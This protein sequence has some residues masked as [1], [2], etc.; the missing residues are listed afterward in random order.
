M[1]KISAFLIAAL[2]S[3][4]FATQ[5]ANAC[6]CGCGVFNV[7]TSALIPNCQ[8]GTAFLQYDYIDQ[9]RNWHKEKKSDRSENEHTQ[10][11]TQTITAGMQYMF[12]R[13]WGLAARIPYVT[14]T[15]KMTM[16][17][18]H[19]GGMGGMEETTNH[20]SRVNSLGDIRINGIYSGFSSDMSSGITFGL[21][22]PT[23]QA[24]A[25][26][27]HERDMQIGTGSTDTL[28]GAYHMGEINDKFNWF[29][30]GNWQHAIATRNNYRPG[31]EISAGS[32]VYYNAGSFAGIKKIAPIVQVTASKKLHDT[33]WNSDAQ[34]SGYSHAYFTPAIE[35][36]F[37]SFKT[38]ADVGFP[39]YQ[40]VNGQQLVATR[41]YKVILG[42]NF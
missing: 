27:F 42:Y 7:G 5:E 11:K 21:K 36:N 34:N 9:N 41:I 3:F 35:L 25:K 10:V 29:A 12:N 37:G 22:L 33:G 14:R 17:H 40:N 38:Y 16:A 2:L 1:K 18:E 30:Q 13:E 23:G 39:I 28:L 6:A 8:G 32:G 31:D 15:S 20:F 19:M 26:A 24:N 4:N